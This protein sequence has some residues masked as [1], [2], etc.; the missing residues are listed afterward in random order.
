MRAFGVGGHDVD[1]ADGGRIFTT[2]ELR[3]LAD[4]FD[5]FGQIALQMILDAI[6]GKSR[7]FAQIVGFVGIDV[8][9]RHLEHVV[10]LVGRGSDDFLWHGGV[11]V[12]VGIVGRD[13]LD[14]AG[15]GHPVQRL[16]GAEF[17]EDQQAVVR[18]DQQHAFGERQEGVQSSGIFG[19][20]V[21]NNN[22]HEALPYHDRMWASGIP[23][24]QSGLPPQLRRKAACNHAA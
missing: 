15:R 9:Q 7:V 17:G 2:H 23:Y 13:V 22:S 24:T 18:L 19:G 6:L 8:L 20:A 14:G 5:L 1:R 16:V 4:T 12:I 21:S 10:R 11:D 3:S